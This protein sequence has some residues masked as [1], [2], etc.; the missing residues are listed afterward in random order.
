MEHGIFAWI[1][2]GGIGLILTCALLAL[3]T[4]IFQIVEIVDVVRRD[5]NDDNMKIVWLLVI[6]FTHFIGALV[7]YFVG[8]SQGT[9][10]A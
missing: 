8:K 7:Y 4:T 10:R 3:A 5:F 1:I 6:I 9:L 2:A